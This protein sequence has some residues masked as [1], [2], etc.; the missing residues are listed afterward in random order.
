MKVGHLDGLNEGSQGPLC[1]LLL[2]CFV[3]RGSLVTSGFLRGA[4]GG[5]LVGLVRGKGSVL[6]S[7]SVSVSASVRGT[8]TTFCV[9]D[10]H[11]RVVRQEAWRGKDPGHE[12]LLHGEA[13]VTQDLRR[14]YDALIRQL[15]QTG[16]QD[17]VSE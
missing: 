15:I 12:L 13:V 2:L 7:V 4:L 11:R 5:V 10:S 8:G 3:P 9:F 17:V 14:R 1:G 16:M 6:G